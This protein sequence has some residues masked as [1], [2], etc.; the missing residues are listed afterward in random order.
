MIKLV[1]II[2]DSENWCPGNVGYNF[3]PLEPQHEKVWD[4]GSQRLI[5]LKSRPYFSVNPF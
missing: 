4:V 5:T 1:T 3:P 2:S